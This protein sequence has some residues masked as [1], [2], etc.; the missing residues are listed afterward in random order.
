M[1]KTVI[2][3]QLYTLREIMKTPQEIVKTLKAVRKI[4]YQAVQLAGL[5]PFSPG[6][7]RQILDGEG[8]CACASHTGLDPIVKETQRVIEEQ[9]IL[10]VKYLVCPGLPMELQN[11][12]GYRKAAKSLSR[13][14]KVFSQA[15]LVLGYH[16]HALELEKYGRKL[17]LEILFSE[18]NPKYLQAEIDT[19]WIAFGGGDPAS[20]CLK[21]AGRLPTVHLK[22][23]GIKKNTQVMTEV[24][25]GNLNWKAIFS[26]CKKA[27]TRWYI[28]EQDICQR[29]PLESVK[30]SLENLHKMGLR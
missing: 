1:K 11:A 20:W 13:A 16:N 27:G 8:L 24:G 14:G 10:G 22:D 21:F 12:A 2:A 18:S 6:E 29:H 9:K 17:G 25:E 5:G 4:G 23:M 30:I 7:Y 19:Y 3:L 15:G 28:V 26:A